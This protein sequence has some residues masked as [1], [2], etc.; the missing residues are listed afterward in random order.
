VPSPLRGEGQGEGVLPGWWRGDGR[1]VEGFGGGFAGRVAGVPGLRQSIG[2]PLHT[3]T[4]SSP[5][6][7]ERAPP[8]S[9]DR[10]PVRDSETVAPPGSGSRTSGPS[11]PPGLPGPRPLTPAA[12]SPRNPPSHTACCRTGPNP[13]EVCGEDAGSGM[14]RKHAV[15]SGGDPSTDPPRS[16]RL[17]PAGRERSEPPSRLQPAESEPKNRLQP[18]GSTRQVT[19]SSEHP[20]A[21]RAP[22]ELARRVDGRTIRQ[23][24]RHGEEP[25]VAARRRC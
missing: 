1:C 19:T 11:S 10:L 9:P 23:V 25:R 18:A 4:L 17:Q 12:G 20:G 2:S 3:P 6:G 8:P 22:T 21:P 24:R 15:E 5:R 7:E 14:S 13:T 16:G